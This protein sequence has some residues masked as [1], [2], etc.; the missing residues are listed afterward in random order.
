MGMFENLLMINFQIMN[1]L[2]IEIVVK[3][4]ICAV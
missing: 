2:K 1:D 4:R 3:D